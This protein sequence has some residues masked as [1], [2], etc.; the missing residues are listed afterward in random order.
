[1][2][3]VAQYLAFAESMYAIVL[4]EGKGF[5]DFSGKSLWDDQQRVKKNGGANIPFLKEFSSILQMLCSK[6]ILHKRQLLQ[7]YIYMYMQM[8]MYM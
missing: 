6:C 1:M 2:D 7:T 8:Y 5:T 4:G 3:V